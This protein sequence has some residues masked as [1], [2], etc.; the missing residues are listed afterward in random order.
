MTRVRMAGEGDPT[1]VHPQRES[2]GGNVR[3]IDQERERL[4]RDYAAGEVTWRDL[5]ERGFADYV[6]VLGG[7]GEL[8]LRPPVAPMTGPNVAARERRR[9]ILRKLLAERR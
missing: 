2:G 7:L 3:M 9:A 4:L 5:Q 1:Y 8:G 6:E